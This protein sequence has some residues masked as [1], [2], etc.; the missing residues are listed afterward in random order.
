MNAKIV[1]LLEEV[2]QDLLY[3]DSIQLSSRHSGK[4]ILK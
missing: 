1:K 3:F 4:W 2:E